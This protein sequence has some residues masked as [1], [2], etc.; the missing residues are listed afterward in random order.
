MKWQSRK[1]LATLGF[2]LIF[3]MLLAMGYLTGD[4]YVRLM[5]FVLPAFVFAQAY[6]DTKAPVAIRLSTKKPP[7]AGEDY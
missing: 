1:F 6:A 4:E 2:G 5:S 7:E 3:T